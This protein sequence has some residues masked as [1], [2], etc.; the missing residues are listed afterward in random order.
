MATEPGTSPTLRWPELV[1]SGDVGPLECVGV[2]DESHDVKTFLLKSVEP[3][4]F[5]YDPGQ[6]ITL[7]CE[8]GGVSV[9]RCYTLSSTPTRPDRA[10]ITAKRHPGG[11]VS[12][13]LHETLKPGSRLDATG[14]SGAFSLVRSTARKVAL[15]AGGSGI[16]P[17]MSMSRYIDD[18]A[19]DLDVVFVQS[20]RTPADLL[21]RRELDAMAARRAGFEVRY[22]CDRPDVERTWAGITGYLSLDL[23]G[24]V[25]PDLLER[26]VYCCGPAPYMGNV[27]AILSE[28]AFDMARYHE[29]SFQIEEPPSTPPQMESATDDVPYFAI[30]FANAG[31]TIRAKSTDTILTAARAAGIPLPS[32]CKRGLCG[33]C[34]TLKL[35]GDVEMNHLGGIRKS[36]I[37]KGFIL[38]CCSRPLS[39]LKLR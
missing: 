15:F 23:L 38:A 31:K 12:R 2:R 7:T 21:F 34:K 13:H 30:E 19:L 32:S 33:T 10:A 11:V 26:E 17:M 29:E 37:D 20:A 14:P 16:T 39:D 5:R 22:A 1:W 35:S 9:S 3:A 27:R 24:R 6:F 4:I 8:I 28:L 18:L 25:L 36:D